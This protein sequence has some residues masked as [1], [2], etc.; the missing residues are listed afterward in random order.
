MFLGAGRKKSLLSVPVT[1]D[2]VLGGSE[3]DLTNMVGHIKTPIGTVEQCLLKKMANGKLGR[4]VYSF[5]WRI[6]NFT[7][8]FKGN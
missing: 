4:Q 3:V 6:S 1:S 5:S 8:A 7:I 2:Y